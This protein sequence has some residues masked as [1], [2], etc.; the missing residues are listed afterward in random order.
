MY[1]FLI[2]DC[3]SAGSIVGKCAKSMANL[4]RK[5]GAFLREMGILKCVYCGR[6]QLQHVRASSTRPPSC[7]LAGRCRG[8]SSMKRGRGRT[9]SLPQYTHFAR[10]DGHDCCLSRRGWRHGCKGL[11][12]YSHYNRCLQRIE[13]HKN[14]SSIDLDTTQK[15]QINPAH[16]PVT[17]LQKAPVHS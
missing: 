3:L 14:C 7:T 17:R 11:S 4:L 9:G 13:S 1:P 5:L 6:D 8:A 10:K 12:P 16:L 15:R 2:A